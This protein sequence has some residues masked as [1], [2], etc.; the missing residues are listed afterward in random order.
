[1]RVKP[2]RLNSLLCMEKIQTINRD[3][4]SNVPL[5]CSLSQWTSEPYESID[6]THSNAA[7][8]VKD[9]TQLSNRDCSQGLDKTQEDSASASTAPEA[10]D[11]KTV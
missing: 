3:Y 8:T 2:L 1:M 7:V 10:T 9:G 5:L 4:C 6:A 11:Q